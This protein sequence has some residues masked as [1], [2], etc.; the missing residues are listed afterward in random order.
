M[1]LNSMAPSMGIIGKP[2]S[3]Q[4]Y[5]VSTALQTTVSTTWTGMWVADQVA[6]VHYE[7]IGNV[8]TAKIY[9]FS[10]VTNANATFHSLTAIP[11]GYR[12]SSD[13]AIPIVV[14]ENAAGAI[15]RLDIVATT[16]I[17]TVGADGA[18]SGFTNGAAGGIAI[19]TVV[20]WVA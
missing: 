12:P 4:T 7:R 16:G 20:S 11:V 17:I 10:A 3:V 6:N 1:A 13:I 8:V 15:G 18:G 2:E 19:D 9:N 14:H 5:N